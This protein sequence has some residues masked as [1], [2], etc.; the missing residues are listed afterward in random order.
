MEQAKRVFVRTKT[1]DRAS[2]ATERA[3]SE[4]HKRRWKCDW[5]APRN[6]LKVV[7]RGMRLSQR[8]D[9]GKGVILTLARIGAWFVLIG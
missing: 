3:S 9:S 8:P 5:A 6:R 7:P 1:A 4:G 2:G